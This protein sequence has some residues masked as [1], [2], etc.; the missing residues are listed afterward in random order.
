MSAPRHLGRP[1]QRREPEAVESTTFCAPRGTLVQGLTVRVSHV[2]N[3][4]AVHMVS[5][6]ISQKHS[7][8]RTVAGKYEETID[9]L[10]HIVCGSD[11]GTHAVRMTHDHRHHDAYDFS[12]VSLLQSSSHHNPST[13][14]LP[15]S[16][17]AIPCPLM[18]VAVFV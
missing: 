11:G 16:R 10:M 18:H 8:R 5:R 1:R 12:V 13:T 15:P 4:P 3:W 7:D 2:H 14:F 6:S 9:T 17:R